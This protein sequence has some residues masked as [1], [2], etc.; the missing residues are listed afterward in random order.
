MLCIICLSYI[1]SINSILLFFNWSRPY[2]HPISTV[3]SF[4]FILSQKNV[5]K[6]IW[7]I[8]K[9]FTSRVVTTWIL[10]LINLLKLMYRY[11]SSFSSLTTSFIQITIARKVNPLPTNQ[12]FVYP[13][14]GTIWRDKLSLKE[15]RK[16]SLQ[17]YQMVTS[18]HDQGAVNWEPWFRNKANL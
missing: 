10:F 15:K 13:F 3:E 8:W 6:L 16:K 5:I 11:S 1:D 17:T 14:F 12:K 18:N 7:I 2:E 4:S 9:Y